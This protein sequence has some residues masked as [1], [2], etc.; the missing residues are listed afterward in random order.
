MHGIVFVAIEHHLR[1]N[2]EEQLVRACFPTPGGYLAISDYPDDDLYRIAQKAAGRRSTFSARPIDDILKQFG[3][4]VPGAVQRI[5]PGSLPRAAGFT[6]LLDLLQRGAVGH[7]SLIPPVEVKRRSDGLPSIVHLGDPRLCRF[8]EG[9]LVGMAS[10]L[11]EPIAF[12]HPTCKARGDAQCEFVARF[13]RSETT[14]VA[15]PRRSKP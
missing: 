14:A 9:L 1:S 6:E 12:R 15:T 13:I 5:A 11:N 4:A 2:R 8:T 10:L 7:R 3:E